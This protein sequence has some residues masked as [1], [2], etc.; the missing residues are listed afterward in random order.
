MSE[1][2]AVVAETT[3]AIATKLTTAGSVT[4]IVSVFAS[5]DWGFW[6]GV[7][8]GLTGLIISFLN[9]L[10]NRQFQKLKDIRDT[11]MHLLESERKR[12]E[13]KKL[14]GVCDVKD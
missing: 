12:L 13:I 4:T 2:G 6:I 8:I 7:V 14:S 11:E 3:T 1:N 10:S 9:Y 5:L